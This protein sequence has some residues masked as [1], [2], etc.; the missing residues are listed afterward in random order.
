MN[1]DGKDQDDIMALARDDPDASVENFN[2]MDGPSEEEAYKQGTSVSHV[3]SQYLSRYL[4][5]PRGIQ[6]DSSA[7]RSAL[8]WQ[9]R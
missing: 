5:F 3:Y 9:G 6:D 8:T 2:S 7:R 1:W 4:Y